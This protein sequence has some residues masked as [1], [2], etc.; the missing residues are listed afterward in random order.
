MNTQELIRQ[1]KIIRKT[2]Y[3]CRLECERARMELAREIEHSMVICRGSEIVDLAE[4]LADL[5]EERQAS[6]EP[7]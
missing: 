1:A 6:G 2:N 5:L 7:S 3:N 4:T